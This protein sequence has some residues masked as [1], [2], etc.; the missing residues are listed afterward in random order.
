MK[1]ILIASASTLLCGVL[2]A[3]EL[4][5]VDEQIEA[6][7]PPRKTSKI[8]N[9][10][11][12]FVYLEK[13]GYVKKVADKKALVSTKLKSSS[14]L[15]ASSLSSTT[16]SVCD[17]EVERPRSGLNLDA[18]LNSSALINGKW[19][20]KSDKIKSYTIVNVD[21]TSVTLKQGNK[22]MTLSTSSK[23]RTLKFKNK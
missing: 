15:T 16:S 21:K 7:K 9:I 12:P 22:K 1:T 8:S 11:N 2:A 17:T 18:I 10:Q 19:Y 5:W 14:G 3:T 23:K 4:T 6:I 20:K 13:N